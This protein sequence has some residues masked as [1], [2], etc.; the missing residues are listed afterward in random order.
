MNILITGSKGQLGSEI[1]RASA[2]YPEHQFFFTDVAELDICNLGDLQ[3]FVGN[4]QINCI[5]NCAA[6]TAVDKAEEEEELAMKINRDAAKNLAE[7]ANQANA[8]LIHVST[9]YVFNGEA[10]TPYTEDLA[11]EPN[12][13]YGRS[14]QAGEEEIKNIANQAAIVRTSWLCSSFGHNFIKTILK[15]GTE[16]EAL[17]VVFD[18]V[19]SPTN[20]ADLA[21]ACLKLA[22]NMDSINGTE[23]FHFSNEGVC[24]WYDFALEIIHQEK[25]T[26]KIN[27]I[28]TAE[29]PLPANR[30]PY[31]VL[32]KKKIKQHLNIEIP[33][34]K[35]GL[36]RIL[37]EIKEQ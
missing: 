19:G 13:A 8:S 21:D 6:Y 26:C 18:Q 5:I 2:L 37:K 3:A 11:T 4:K 30:P 7:V 24:S 22:Q 17:N 15:Y 27:P 10:F 12:S 23:V 34:W 35:D 33:H 25:I 20:A 1:K 32:D 28:R 29:Y 9:D 36:T 31:S 16:R 14:K